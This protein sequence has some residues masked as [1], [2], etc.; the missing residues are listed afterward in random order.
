MRQFWALSEGVST[1]PA[2]GSEE[3]RTYR[4]LTFQ[5]ARV[6]RLPGEKGLKR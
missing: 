1:R 6:K 2:G 3:V 5:N 4:A